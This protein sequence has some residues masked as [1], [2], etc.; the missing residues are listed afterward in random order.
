[1]AVPRGSFGGKVG[2]SWLP[3]LLSVCHTTPEILN[4]YMTEVKTGVLYMPYNHKTTSPGS[5]FN[6]IRK[7]CGYHSLNLI[8]NYLQLEELTYYSFLI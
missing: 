8:Y 6:L 7:V 4:K 3:T 1:M 2:C 5:Y